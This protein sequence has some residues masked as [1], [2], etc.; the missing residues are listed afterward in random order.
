M[1]I[2]VYY[3]VTMYNCDVTLLLLGVYIRHRKL[4][5]MHECS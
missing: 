2:T 3:R 4:Y 1:I 5:L